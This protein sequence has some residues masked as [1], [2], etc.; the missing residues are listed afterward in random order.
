MKTHTSDHDVV[1]TEINIDEQPFQT[2]P[3]EFFYSNTINNPKL[4]ELEN[5]L[6]YILKYLELVLTNKMNKER[7]D[8][9]KK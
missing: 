2:E 1:E 3:K 5:Y 7:F 6:E 8:R 4:Q 9:I